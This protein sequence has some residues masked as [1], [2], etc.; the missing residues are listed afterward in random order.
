MAS[1][2]RIVFGI[3]CGAIGYFIFYRLGHIPV[4][5]V[6][7]GVGCAVIIILVEAII[8]RRSARQAVSGFI[9]LAVGLTVANLLSYVVTL[10]VRPTVG[11]RILLFVFANLAFGYLGVVLAVRKG[12]ELLSGNSGFQPSRQGLLESNKILD[13]SVIIDG[14]IADVA[15]AHFLEGSLVIPRFV[16]QELQHIADSPDD[17]RR[18]RGRR[19]LDIL[20]RLQAQKHLK[21]RIEDVDVAENEQVDSRIVR[22][23]EQRGASIIT[24]DYNLNKVADLHGVV[25]LNM[26][27]LAGAVKPVFLPGEELEVRLLKRGKESGQGVGYLEDGTMVVVDEGSTKLGRTV[28]S[29]VTS[30][31]QT[32]A[33]RMIFAKLRK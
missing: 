15:E 26:N 1:V 8:V 29:V 25:V 21:V 33:G 3:F 20:K 18:A 9:G 32:T 12:A 16:L 17:L 22:L 2:V 14:R 28:V 6:L 7:L 19:G 31:L 27:D 11:A 13:T 10:V 23:A 24:T 4:V 30:V 5:G